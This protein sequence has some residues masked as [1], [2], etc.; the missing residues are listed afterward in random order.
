VGERF[1]AVGQ[2]GRVTEV[3]PPRT[4]AWEWSAERY[5]FDLTPDGSGC[6]LVFT[7]VFDPSLAPAEQYATGWAAYLLRLDVHLE[8]GFLSEEDALAKPLATLD[9]SPALRFERRLPHLPE[10]VWRALCDPEELGH[11]FPSD[12][13]IVVEER[14]PPRL[15]AGTWFGDPVRFE[16]EPDD[17]GCV[18]RFTHAFADRD[19]AARTAAGWDRSLARLDALLGG[20]PMEEAASL[21]AWPAVHERYAAAFGVDPELGRRAYAA[22]PL[23]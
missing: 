13:P 19:T 10:R 14:V 12:E 3:D 16:L 8:G 1:E 23:T 17:A 20:A 7:H 5:R 22:H 21:E 11:W 2:P 18:L 15:L 4:L 6:V 9:D